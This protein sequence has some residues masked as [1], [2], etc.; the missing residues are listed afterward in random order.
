MRLGVLG[1][2][3]HPYITLQHDFERDQILVLQNGRK[4]LIYKGLKP[5]Y[6]SPSSESALAEAEIEYKDI[7]SKSIYFKLPIV[8]GEG[9]YKDAAFM[10]WTTTPWT[11]PGNL[12][13][14]AGPDI[15]Y[16]LFDSNKGKMICATDLLASLTSFLELSDVKVLDHKQGNE[17]LNLK[18]KHPLYDRISPVINADYVTTTDGTGFVSYCSRLR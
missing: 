9:D 18:Y 16:T 14:C 10:V 8:N 4:G 1:D 6:W 7:T 12:A 11:L 15:N 17:L 13:V 5:V 3:E 2:F